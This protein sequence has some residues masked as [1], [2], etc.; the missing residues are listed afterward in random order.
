MQSATSGVS[1]YVIVSI[2]EGIESVET[3]LV[4]FKGLDHTNVSITA[5]ATTAQNQPESTANQVACEAMKVTFEVREIAVR[6]SRIIAVSADRCKC[7]TRHKERNTRQNALH[8]TLTQITNYLPNVIVLLNRAPLQ[9]LACSV[10][11]IIRAR[12]FVQ[13]NKLELRVCIEGR[14]ETLRCTDSG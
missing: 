8:D 1:D 9:P 13:Q 2:P 12:I 11:V 4:F 5:G 10:R 14:H 7:K 3:C 6:I